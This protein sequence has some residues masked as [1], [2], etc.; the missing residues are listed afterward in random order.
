MN[1]VMTKIQLV[2][3]IGGVLA[4][5]LDL[6]WDELVLQANLPYNDIRTLYRNEIRKKLWHGE[7]SEK[8]FWQWLVTTFP[9]IDLN[10]LQNVLPDSLVELEGLHHVKSWSTFADIHILS[11]HRTEWVKPIIDQL[12]PFVKSVTV[13]AEVSVA[14]PNLPIY[15]ICRQNL[16]T[17]LPVLFVDNKKE[18]LEPA[19]QLGW[20]TILADKENVW[21]DKVNSRLFQ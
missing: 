6:F 11:N 3:D 21:I 19:Q 18:N 16:D 5:D 7:I 4:T 17:H 10:Y 20:E 12:Q 8:A 14:K 13:S 9:K 15:Q 1:I 2:L